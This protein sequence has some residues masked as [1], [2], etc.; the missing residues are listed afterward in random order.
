MGEPEIVAGA[1]AQPLGQSVPFLLK[2]AAPGRVERDP[3]LGGITEV[4]LVLGEQLGVDGV[5]ACLAGLTG[6][7]LRKRLNSPVL[8]FSYHFRT[9][10]AAVAEPPP[11]R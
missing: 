8:H 4:F 3:R 9:G 7:F 6:C 5:V 2:L 1:V 10:A 11:R